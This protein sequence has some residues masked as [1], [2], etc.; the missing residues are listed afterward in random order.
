MA[1]S[2]LAAAS[3]GLS[4]AS[5]AVTGISSSSI[6]RRDALRPSPAQ[7]VRV[8]PRGAALVAAAVATSAPVA[9]V[10][11]QQ[12]RRQLEALPLSQLR[13]MARARGISGGGSKA[14][15]ISDLLRA[16][17]TSSSSASQPTSA[18]SAQQPASAPQAAVGV[19][20]ADEAQ[21]LEKRLLATPL[22]ALRAM[23]R[24][25]GL[26][27]NTKEELVAALVAATPSLPSSV[28][29]SSASASASSAYPAASAPL[30]SNGS[31]AAFVPA[32]AVAAPAAKPSP[33]TLVAEA[34]APA[35]FILPFQSEFSSTL[36][37]LQAVQLQEELASLREAMAA[38]QADQKVISADREGLREQAGFLRNLL[39]GGIGLAAVP[40]LLPA[41]IATTAATGGAVAGAAGGV[42]QVLPPPQEPAP[43]VR[44]LSPEDFCKTLPA[45]LLSPQA[46]R[47]CTAVNQM[48]L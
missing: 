15:L 30:P 36:T 38:L 12:Q 10:A 45:N 34:P 13:A 5:P 14:D 46:A 1:C 29:V 3:S 27:G 42:T 19:E 7:P 40:L 44:Q 48:G 16:A 25:K 8:A 35:P 33:V 37:P 31:V 26:R 9:G 18:A 20:P 39:I 17:D 22:A 43:E 24:Q 2:S 4:F 32:R 21:G 28:P 23:A 47:F 11:D 6:A 41:Q